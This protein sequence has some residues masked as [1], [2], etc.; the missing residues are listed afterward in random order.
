MGVRLAE[1]Q[2]AEVVFLHVVEAVD[3]V[4]PSLGPILAI[5]HVLGMP[6]EDEALADAAEL[7]R[8]HGVPYALRLVSGFDVETIKDTADEIDAELIVVGSNHHGSIGTMLL[9]SVSMSLLKHATRPIV[10]VHPVP[11]PAAVAG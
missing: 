3:V 4:A 6:E 10:V 11:V 9:G 5:P 8:A 1:E 2:G 7:A